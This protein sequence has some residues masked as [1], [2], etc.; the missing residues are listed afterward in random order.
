MTYLFDNNFSPKLAHMLALA[1]VDAIALRN[2][3]REDIED[4]DFLPQ[5]KDSG[6]VLMTSDRHIKTRNAEALALHEA[7]I[8][9]LFFKPFFI[10]MELRGQAAWLLNNW[11]RI[12]EFVAKSRVGTVAEVPARGQIRRI[13]LGR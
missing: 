3:F 8:T 1:D 7:G 10:K 12:E 11:W 4:E 9:A 2:R 5:L 13:S 6:M